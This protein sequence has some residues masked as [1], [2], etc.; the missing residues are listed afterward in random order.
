[1]RGFVVVLMLLAPAAYP[2]DAPASKPEREKR[3]RILVNG[4]YNA[5]ALEFSERSTFE[6]YLEEGESRRSYDGGKGFVFEAGA[7]VSVWKELGVM[8]SFELYQSEIDASYEETLPHPL[9]FDEPRTVSGAETG[10]S[11]DERAFHV[12]AVY[13]KEFSSI[14]VDL[15]GGPT[16]FFTTTEVLDQ[17]DTASDYPF[18]E[19]AVSGTST[20]KVDD[21]PIGF[22]AGG[23][24]TF[25]LSETFGLAAQAR[26][27]KATIRVQRASGSEVEL[28]AGGLRVGGGIRISF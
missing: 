23:A 9:Y 28:D 2:Q 1:V 13:S 4:S 10:L 18:D 21:D 5:T 24:V 7:I 20:V 17:V 22:N 14:T 27:S 6:S 12:D 16:F 26:Y 8:G 3:V 25:R 15:F 19:V 11:Y